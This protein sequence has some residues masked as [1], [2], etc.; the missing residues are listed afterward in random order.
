ME[1]RSSALGVAVEAIPHAPA[2][3]GRARRP[4]RSDALLNSRVVFPHNHSVFFRPSHPRRSLNVVAFSLYINAARRRWD[5]EL[6]RLVPGDNLRLWIG[7]HGGIF[8]AKLAS[9]A[10]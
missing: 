9:S 3:P 6:L 10:F 7:T 4:A 8:A 2:A 5:S 1:Q